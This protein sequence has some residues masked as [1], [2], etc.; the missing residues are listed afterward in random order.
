MDPLSRFATWRDIFLQ[1]T[2]ELARNAADVLP[3]LLGVI[4]VLAI[5]WLLAAAAEFVVGRG[6][7]G[8]GFDHASSRVRMTD[9]F[10][11][12]GL[13]TTP[14]DVLGKLTFWGVLL[15]VSASMAGSLGF[16][17]LTTTTERFIAFLPDLIGAGLTLL[18][19]LVMARFVGAVF[20]SAAAAA[21][22]LSAPRLGLLA[23]VLVAGLVAVVALEQLGVSTS[24]LVGPLTAVLGTVGFAAGLAFALGAYPIVTH[25]L[26]GHFLKQSLPRDTFVEVGGERGVVDRVGPTDTVLRSGDRSWSV[27]NGKLIEEVVVR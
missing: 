25:I 15:S 27:P 3:R 7:R 13:R 14:S 10:E 20:G 21:G 5:S 19:G 17:V 16:S 2:D 12:A 4:F 18:L 6:L 23:Q 1:A 9:I 24:V 22:F 8:V 11:R 26:A